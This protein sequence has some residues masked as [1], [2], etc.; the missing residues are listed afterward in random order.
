MSSTPPSSTHYLIVGGGTAGLVIA[1]RLSENPEVN[2]LVLEA[3]PDR[4]SD[5]E[6]QNP[7]AWNGLVGSEVDWNMKFAPQVYPPYVASLAR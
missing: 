6:I 3:G 1:N 4:T 5:L 2:V 7:D